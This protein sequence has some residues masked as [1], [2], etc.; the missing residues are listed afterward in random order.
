MMKVGSLSEMTWE[1]QTHMSRVGTSSS[2]QGVDL[3]LGSGTRNCH[4]QT[5][6]SPQQVRRGQLHLYT[7][8][9][10]VDNITIDRGL[11]FQSNETVFLFNYLL[12]FGS[13]SKRFSGTFVDGYPEGR[14][15]AE[16]VIH[17]PSCPSTPTPPVTLLP[18]NES[19]SLSTG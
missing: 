5:H 7:V 12:Q 6:H 3:E 10:Q 1:E 16:R 2:F 4:T 8:F 14:C 15:V 9:G 11:S 17:N 13:S 18:R 19:M